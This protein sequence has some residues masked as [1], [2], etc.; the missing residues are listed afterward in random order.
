MLVNSR[1]NVDDVPLG[2]LFLEKFL[3]LLSKCC[4]ILLGVVQDSLDMENVGLV[5]LGVLVDLRVAVPVEL[6]V[7]LEQ[8]VDVGQ[9]PFILI[10]VLKGFNESLSGDLIAFLDAAY[11]EEDTGVSQGLLV[12]LGVRDGNLVDFDGTS[13][14]RLD[15]SFHLFL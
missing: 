15:Y 13:K 2:V 10:L 3:N 6:G 11:V 7:P 4:G 1:I 8:G 5:L 12:L 9:N 14:E